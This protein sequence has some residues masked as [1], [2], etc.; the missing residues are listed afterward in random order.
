MTWVVIKNTIELDME[1]ILMTELPDS[2]P[3]RYK[4]V[5]S[6]SKL[7]FLIFVLI[8]GC[9]ESERNEKLKR[10]KFIPVMNVITLFGR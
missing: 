10:L 6:C 3:I 4:P 2:N 9:S 7:N 1:R 8:S 5:L